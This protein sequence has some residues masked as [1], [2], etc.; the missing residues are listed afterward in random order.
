MKLY[1]ITLVGGILLLLAGL[2]VGVW[3]QEPPT[4]PVGEPPVFLSEYYDAWVT[5]PHADFTSAAFTNWD[6]DGSIPERC[7]TC[8]S[9]TGYL[10]YLGADGTEARVVD[11]PAALGTVVNCDACHNPTAASLTTVM[12]PSGIEVTDLSDSTRCMV[13]HQGRASTVSVNTA[14]E[15]AGLTEDVDTVN[16]ELGFINIHYNPAAASLYGAEVMGGYQYAGKSYQPRFEH[17]EGYQTCN[18]CHNPHTTE[19][20]LDECTTCHVDVETEEDLPWIRM[21]GS[22]MDYDGDGDDFEGIAGEIETLQ[23]MLYEAIQLY[24]NVVVGTPIAY[25]S[26]SH[27]YFFIDTD[28]SGEAEEEEAIGDNRYNA[29]TARLLQAAY[30][31]QVSMKDPGNYAHNAKY[32]IELLYDSIESLNEALGDDS[33]DLTFAVRN[34]AGHFD[35]TAEA[36]RHWD[37]DGEVPGNCAKC[38]TGSGL[39]TFLKN[40]TNIAV[41][42]SN[43]L[44]C[45]TCHDSVVDF[46]LYTVDQV[47]MPSGAR[48]SFG[49]GD[50]NNVCLNC[51]QGREST[52]SVNNAINRA[53]VGDDEVT[54]ALTFRNVHYFAAGASLFGTEA[55]GAYEFADKEYNGRFLHGEDMETCTSCHNTHSLKLDIETCEECHEDVRDYEDIYL[56]RFDGEDVE[57][58]DYDGD[59][60]VEEPVYDELAAYEEALWNAIYTYTAETVGTPIAYDAHAYPY[61]FIDSNGNGTTDPDEANYGNQYVTWTPNL[62]RAAYNYQFAQKDPGKFAHNA[63]YML[64]VL[65]DSIEAVGGADAV[66]GLNRAP[67]TVSE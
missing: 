14:I 66:A 43:S 12:F 33:I 47:T 4:N 50:E 57:P 52:V 55:K 62:L 63:D 51:H 49:E 19:L 24:A 9:T 21:Q 35:A 34:D 10:D 44:S 28:G 25:E 39:P 53:A 23:E 1:H 30:N 15:N 42:P 5:S 48:I 11:A 45:S 27:P 8:H 22:M 65:Y 61:W 46:T 67:V 37:E 64:Q 54:D 17:V 56:I 41:T 38:H 36:F 13:C 3:A 6:E 2:T 40:N 26:H 58:V 31:Y 32:H 60:D 20:K 16:A 29:F 59:G 18:D 7:A